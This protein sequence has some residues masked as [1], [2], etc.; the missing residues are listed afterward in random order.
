[1][2]GVDTT[3]TTIEWVMTELLNHPREME[4]VHQELTQVV[5]LDKMVEESHLPRLTHLNDVVKETLRLH[6]PFALLIPRRPSEA[7]VIGGY[8]IPKTTKVFINAWSI[9]RDPEIWE[10]PLEFRPSRFSDDVNT[11]FDYSGN[12][13]GFVPFGSGRRVCAGIPLA[14]KVMN[15]TLASLLHSFDWRSPHGIVSHDLSDKFGIVVKKLEPLVAIPSTRL[16]NLNLYT[17]T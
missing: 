13:F 10:N 1:M 7:A 3:V 9:H 17:E 4:K 6:P 11:K 16:T 14:E 12:N 15:Y 5:G 8:Y 2:G